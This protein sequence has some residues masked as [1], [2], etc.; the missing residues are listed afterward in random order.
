M[1]T[2]YLNGEFLPKEE[3]RI[4]VDDR[5]FLLSDGI[6][7]VSAAYRGRFF[8]M[9]RHLDRMRFGL[10]ELRIA[11]DPGDLP[12]VHE[13]LLD[14]NGLGNVE[15]STVYVQVT[16]GVA[17]RTHHFPPGPVA[18]SVYAF[19][20]EFIRPSREAWE[21][22][23]RSI[24]VP[25]RRWSRVDI[26]SIALL[27]NVLAQQAAVDAGARDAILVK[28]GIAVEGSHN[29]LFAV[30]GETVVTHPASNLILHGITREY[31]LELAMGL[32]YP[33]EER[34]LQV[35]EIY[36]AEELFFTGTTTEVR[37]TVSVD[38]RAIGSGGVGPVT[39]ALYDAFLQGVAGAPAGAATA[40]S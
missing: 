36:S 40:R 6:Y 39:R 5:G 22:G 20:S 21:R 1:S 34:A 30:F 10:R 35:E 14:E 18:P 4:S 23:Y 11:Y 12:E 3:A 33:V 17:P 37:P 15:V 38:G 26:K 8:R 32:G 16:R 29:N 27:P 7:E 9:D 19:A 28:D 24:T 13:R 25:D 2:V 31:V